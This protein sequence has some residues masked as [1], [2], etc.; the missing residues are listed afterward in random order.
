MLVLKSGTNLLIII[1]RQYIKQLGS[2]FDIL[3]TVG[4]LKYNPRYLIG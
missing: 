1:S 4:V 3:R 2:V